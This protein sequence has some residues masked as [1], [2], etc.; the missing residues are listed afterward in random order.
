MAESLPCPHSSPL[1]AP[2]GLTGSLEGRSTG[3]S[4]VSVR[5]VRTVLSETGE[6]KEGFVVPGQV[7]EGGVRGDPRRSSKTLETVI[8]PS[9]EA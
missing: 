2:V 3:G 6:E 5:S 8:E 9:P 4:G 1:L 7:G